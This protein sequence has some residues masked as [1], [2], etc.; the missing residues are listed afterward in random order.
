MYYEIRK[1][2][3][4]G[5]FIVAMICSLSRSGQQSNNSITIEAQP[6]VTNGFPVV[7]KVT[8]EG[9]L[10][11]HYLSLFEEFLSVRAHLTSKSDGKEFVIISHRTSMEGF[12]D[13]P[14]DAFPPE[15]LTVP[16]GKK[17][18]M[19]FDLWSL[20]PELT[21]MTALADVPAGK[22]S[23]YIE[24]PLEKSQR[25]SLGKRRVLSTV[26]QKS[27]TIDIE[28]VEPTEQEKQYIQKACESIDRVGWSRWG[29]NWSMILQFRKKIP[30]DG[31][32]S[33]SDISKAQI[34]FHKLLA[35]VN[36]SD[37]KTRNKSI[38]DV[39]DAKLPKFF[40]PERQLLLLELKGNPAKE[41]ANLI[42][43]YPQMEGMVNRIDSEKQP[44]LYYKE[45][46]LEYSKN[47]QKK[48]DP[49]KP[50]EPNK[51]NR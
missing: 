51:P 21:T 17:Y 19:L 10:D 40:E 20:S 37:E 36:I 41:R 35:D 11:F 8:V 15:I 47:S 34:S 7:I 25:S 4:C 44:L 48:I 50:A 28:L 49:N 18:T 29:L 22:Y 5:L 13:G 23:I 32:A 12:W 43:K 6:K 42:Q 31:L 2:I 1:L 39:N 9:T 33:L 14:P 45:L 46:E 3:I 30:S 38:K 16:S 26:I 27:D 24:L